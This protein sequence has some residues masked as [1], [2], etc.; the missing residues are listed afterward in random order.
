M[1]LLPHQEIALLLETDS[2][3]RAFPIPLGSHIVIERCHVRPGET[4]ERFWVN[5]DG[6]R[7]LTGQRVFREVLPPQPAEAPENPLYDELHVKFPDD[8]LPPPGSGT[9]RLFR[10][11]MLS[12][13]RGGRVK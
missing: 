5:E 1:N 13:R 2:R 7:A 4:K 11:G 6:E 3:L 10:R 12:L 8:A 9:R